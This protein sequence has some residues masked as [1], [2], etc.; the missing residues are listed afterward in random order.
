[1]HASSP[2]HA[3]CP[4][5]LM[6]LNYITVSY[7]TEYQ[8][9]IVSFFTLSNISNMFSRPYGEKQSLS[10]LP[11]LA[12]SVLPVYIPHI[13]VLHGQCSVLICITVHIIRCFPFLQ[14]VLTGS[15][16]HPASYPMGSE[17]SFPKC[18]GAGTW[19]WPLTSV[20]CRS[21]EWWTYNSTLPYVFM[22]WCLIKCT[23]KFTCI[24]TI[25]VVFYALHFHIYFPHKGSAYL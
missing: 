13:H 24:F 10:L 8:R 18:K 11:Y 4:A 5:R 3:I 19:S 7:K 16:A 22:A 12:V 21:Q 20:L 1:M 14:S 25:A 15:G 2:I 17:G 9:R 6:P 23:D